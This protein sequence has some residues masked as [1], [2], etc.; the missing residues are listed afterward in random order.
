M[1]IRK[2]LYIFIICNLAIACS[3]R[4]NTRLSRGYHNL[5]AHYNVYFNGNESFKHGVVKVREKVKND[6]SRVLPLFEF[7]DKGNV[8]VASADMDRAIQKGIKLIQ[9]HSITVKPSKK[10]SEGSEEYQKFYKQREF[11]KWVDDA[12]LLIGKAQFY[13]HEFNQTIMTFDMI[14]RDFPNN[15]TAFEAKIWKAVAYSEKGDY[16]NAKIALESYDSSGDAPLSL[17]G[18]YMAVYADLLLRMDDYKEAVPY[19]KL[20]V[21]DAPDRWTRR[22]YQYV[23]AQSLELSGFHREAIEAYEK[24]LKLRPPYEMAFNAKI[25][26]V[27]IVLDGSSTED[28]KREIHHLL[29]DKKNKNFRDRIYY[30]LANVNLS[31][32]NEEEAI[33]NLKLSTKYSVDND[34]QKALSF[35]KMGDI[36]FER[37][38]YRPAFMAYDSAIVFIPNTDEQYSIISDKYQSLKLLVQNIEIVEREDSLQNLA[39]LSEPE[40]LAAL[41]KIIEDEQKRL[42]EEKR[43]NEELAMNENMN[44]QGGFQT[45]TASN[46]QGKWYFYNP[47]SINMGKSEF[48]RRWGRRT[49][50]DNWRRSDKRS[51]KTEAEESPGLPG[52]VNDTTSENSI[53]LVGGKEKTQD[54]LQSGLTVQSLLKDIPL[55]DSAMMVSDKRIENALLDMGMIYR[56]RLA[57]YPKAEETFE[58]LLNRYPEGTRREEAYVELYQAYS[59]ENNQE[60]MDWVHQKI[61]QEFPESKF[62]AYLN[63]PEFFEKQEKKRL[64]VEKEYEDT[65]HNY[66]S[67]LYANV[68]KSVDSIL[69][70]LDDDDSL[71]PKY[72]LLKS[73]SYARQG[74]AENFRNTLDEI[75]AKHAGTEEAELAKSF[76]AEL[77]AGR[78]PVKSAAYKSELFAGRTEYS[79]TNAANE[80]SAPSAL[81]MEPESKHSLIV[82][83]DPRADIN[84][85]VFNFADYNFGRFLL[86]DY[87]LITHKLPDGSNILE[88]NGFNNKREVMDYFY[89][90]RQHPELFK[91]KNAGNALLFST[92]EN[93]LKYLLSSGD[94]DGCILYFIKNYLQVTPRETSQN[95]SISTYS[96]SYVQ[97]IVE[98]L[99]EEKAKSENESNQNI[100][101]GYRPNKAPYLFVISY[102]DSRV[103]NSRLQSIF[104][105]F[106]R[107][108][109]INPPVE[110][111]IMDLSSSRK[112]LVVKSFDDEKAVNNYMDLVKKNT[113]TTRDLS[114]KK[115]EM[116][117]I[118]E[119]NF[120]QLIKD[121]TIDKYFEFIDKSK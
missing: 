50:E 70:Q 81:T 43:R 49:L 67:G 118:S 75:V 22:R 100:L 71:S 45:N 107:N 56:D 46:N 111:E 55:T 23:L 92:S 115:H 79:I 84:R 30:A 63:D 106:N 20:A 28:I 2:V 53:D 61:T 17:Y 87:E 34:Q 93:N 51:L 7:S 78:I 58:E 89:S 64:Q 68:V 41:N 82:I 117:V 52:E 83:T 47:N 86:N 40:R 69:T 104:I 13:K 120:K 109:R 98:I 60:G 62:A 11:N 42:E 101:K 76:L 119:E 105:G 10:G 72:K 85:L 18:F 113:F 74:D 3:T 112:I 33:K 54:Q 32:G 66:L 77:D 48:Q 39:K 96:L 21:E 35:I 88:V 94:K 31:E 1:N 57:D 108:K 95:D 29:R 97:P 24:V 99:E 26:K 114:S 80:N 12:Y 19:L 116:F 36:Y 38:E 121:Q 65:Y 16:T 25:G 103:N 110:V 73:L 44:P 14:I 5:T 102:D 4:K 15:K 6:Y 37:P 91:V 90:V 59:F 8:S 9:K 27:T